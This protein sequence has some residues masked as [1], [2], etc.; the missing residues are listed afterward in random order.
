MNRKLIGFFAVMAVLILLAAGA[1]ALWLCAASVSDLP[2]QQAAERWSPDGGYAQVTAVIGT[3]KSFSE[4]S[5]LSFRASLDQKLTE[6]SIKA[7]SDD[8]RLFADAYSTAEQKITITSDRGRVSAGVFAVGGDF[9]MFHPYTPISGYYFSPN[10]LMS[11]RIV[12]DDDLAWQLFGA[13]DVA[14]FTVEIS[15]ETFIIAAVVDTSEHNSLYENA[16]GSTAKAY[17]PYESYVRLFGEAKIMCYEILLP[18]PVSGFAYEIVSSGISSAAKVVENSA[19]FD[20][21]NLLDKARNMGNDAMRTE[22][23][24]YPYWENAAAVAESRAAAFTMAYMI[25]AVIGFVIVVVYAFAMWFTSGITV[26]KIFTGISDRI[27][28]KTERRRYRRSVN[29]QKKRE[30]RIFRDA[31][32]RRLKQEKKLAKKAKKSD[33]KDEDS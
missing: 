6:A 19:R 24:I 16:Y 5:V 25:I 17:I 14:G 20:F 13:I 22:S 30:E 15:G 31:E 12:I 26:K 23:V 4:Y 33:N 28:A 10:D 11:D 9:F 7:E 32:K 8:V 18:N 29:R 2:E 1:A 21:L 3:D 27:S